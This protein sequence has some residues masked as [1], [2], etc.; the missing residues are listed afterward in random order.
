MYVGTVHEYI[1]E[2]IRKIYSRVP[3][4]SRS[5]FNPNSYTIGIG[6]TEAQK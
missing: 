3:G 2:Q 6:K 1:D 5:D 4:P